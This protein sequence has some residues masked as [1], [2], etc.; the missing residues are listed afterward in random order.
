MATGKV[1]RR[2]KR[3]LQSEITRQNRAAKKQ[4]LKEAAIKK[5]KKE[6]LPF[7][8]TTTIKPP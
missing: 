6:P 4:R 8:Q 3:R 7:A 1:Q 2:T 5:R